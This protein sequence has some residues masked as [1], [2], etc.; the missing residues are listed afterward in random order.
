[1]YLK[2]RDAQD[3]QDDPPTAL[4]S[5]PSINKNS[6]SG[7]IPIQSLERC[8]ALLVR[9]FFAPVSHSLILCCVAVLRL[10][11]CN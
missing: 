10:H 8:V 7:E 3:M 6:G 4:I 5:F 2:L 9:P 1:M 11:R